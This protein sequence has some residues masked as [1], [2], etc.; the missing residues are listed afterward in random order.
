MEFYENFLEKYS[1]SCRVQAKNAIGSATIIYSKE[2]NT[3]AITNHH[4][5]AG[6][7]F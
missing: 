6:R 1:T 4:V 3:F 7:R 2:G 5:I